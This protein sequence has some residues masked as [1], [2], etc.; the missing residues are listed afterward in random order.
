[1]ARLNGGNGKMTD[2][3]TLGNVISIIIFIAGLAI[4]AAVISSKISRFMGE[5]TTDRH[6]MHVELESLSK[7]CDEC[8]VKEKVEFLQK[9]RERMN[10]EQVALR[11]KLPFELDAIKN[12]LKGLKEAVTQMKEIVERRK[13]PRDA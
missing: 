11:A 5:S 3:V 9:E 7:R 13:T 8:Y 10:E 1:M 12:E 4:N 2:T 6:A